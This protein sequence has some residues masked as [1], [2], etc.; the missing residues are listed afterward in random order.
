MISTFS[1]LKRRCCASGSDGA[2]S[3]C[4]GCCCGCGGIGGD[5][6][7]VTTVTQLNF[8][9]R[10]MLSSICV[11]LADDERRMDVVFGGIVGVGIVGA[12]G[13]FGAAVGGVVVVTTTTDVLRNNDEPNNNDA[14]AA[15][16]DDADMEVMSVTETAVAAS[17]VDRERSGG[18]R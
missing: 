5:L 15:D 2:C 7:A 3:S 4:C 13:E 16:E 8:M 14:D 18:V 12:L 11:M 6:A 17:P 10:S 1:L 9:M